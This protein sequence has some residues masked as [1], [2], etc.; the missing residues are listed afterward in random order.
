MILERYREY[1][2]AMRRNGATVGRSNTGKIENTEAAAVRQSVVA[3]RVVLSGDFPAIPL[4]L[5]LVSLVECLAELAVAVDNK[6]PKRGTSSTVSF[7][8]SMH[9]NDL[10]VRF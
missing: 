7:L 4:R 9:N 6:R 3:E 1:V 10:L 5:N 2:E 8:K